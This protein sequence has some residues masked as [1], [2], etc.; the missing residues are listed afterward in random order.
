M[1]KVGVAVVV[2]LAAFA[3]QARSQGP[4]VRSDGS[5]ASIGVSVSELTDAA[6]IGANVQRGV[7]VQGVRDG[8]PASRAG[9]RSGDVI[10]EFDGEA[11]RSAR[12]FARLVQEARPDRAV[13]AVVVRNGTRQSLSVTPQAGI[14]LSAPSPF[15]EPFSRQGTTILKELPFDYDG[16]IP[17]N[18]WFT[19]SA[20]RLGAAVMA[21]D[22]QLA[23]YFGVNDGVLVT[24]VNAN[25]PASRAGVKAG[26]VIVEVAGRP[27]AE[28]QEVA[29]AVRTAEPG[30]EIEVHLIRDKKPI[31]V[32]LMLPQPV[33]PIARGD[34]ITI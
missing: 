7:L 18:G 22:D 12:Q 4:A 26:D 2:L 13:S 16:G 31:A 14:G 28:A 15:V 11:V 3:A 23:S 21:L 27:V 33:R 9:I 24:S 25:S 32:K 5:A 34:R 8:S 19:P 30:G 20:G 10:V 29:D 17:P 6:A 1:R